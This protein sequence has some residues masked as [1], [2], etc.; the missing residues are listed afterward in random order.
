MRRSVVV[1][2]AAVIGGGA[3]YLGLSGRTMV[4][5]S[6]LGSVTQVVNT[7][8]IGVTYSR[9]VARGRTLFGPEGVVPYGEFWNP[10]AND[11]TWIEFS[12][13]VI[14]AGDSIPAGSYSLWANPGAAEWQVALSRDWD[15]FHVPYPGAESDFLRLTLPVTTGEHVEV[16]TFDFEEVGPNTTALTFKW[17]AT[18]VVFP[19]T[20]EMELPPSG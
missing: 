2:A 17:G 6:Q 3:A 5:L 11:A 12:R 19:I 16:M 1:I 13:D 15:V 10:G 4:P 18:R 8:T 9:P 20:V 14:L 7:T